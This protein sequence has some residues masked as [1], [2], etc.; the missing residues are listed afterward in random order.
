MQG[1][2]NWLWNS[3]SYWDDFWNDFCPNG[4]PILI[5]DDYY[6]C[7]ICENSDCEHWREYHND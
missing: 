1:Y 5:N 6:N 7:E 4:E 2:D 3:A